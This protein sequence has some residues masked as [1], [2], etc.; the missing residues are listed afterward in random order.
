[1]IQF[2]RFRFQFR[3]TGVDKRT[4]RKETKKSEHLRDRSYTADPEEYRCSM[5]EAMDEG[6]MVQGDMVQEDME[7]KDVGHEVK[8]SAK[9]RRSPI[10]DNSDQC[11]AS[12]SGWIRNYL[13]VRIR[14]R[15]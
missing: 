10:M 4:R 5:E 3:N 7:Q 6:D 14:I 13:Q 11:C 2:R 9:M 8:I 15:N 12:G 1:M